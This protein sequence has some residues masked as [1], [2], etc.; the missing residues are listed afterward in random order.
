MKLAVHESGNPN[1]PAIIFLHGLGVSSWMW[2]DQIEALKGDYYCLAIDLPGNGESHQAKWVS[3]D[4]TADQLAEIIRSKTFDGHA[5]VVGLSLGG[6]TALHLAARYPEQ[7]LSTVVS[8]VTA[9]PL[10]RSFLHKPVSALFSR[11][12]KFKLM[13]RLSAHMMQFPEDI[14]PVYMRDLERMSSAMIY[15]VYLEVLDFKVPNIPAESSKNLLI[16][17]GD[18][19]AGAVIKSF[20]VFSEMFPAATV[21]QAPHAHHG[22]SGEHPQLFSDMISAWVEQKLLPAELEILHQSS[23]RFVAA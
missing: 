11:M 3:F 20:K 22:W 14:I 13:G 2:H 6:Y 9:V 17:G 12:L 23:A 18:K 7:V 19:E 21:V 15:A 10:M 1:H 8:G 16:S 5:H 4:D